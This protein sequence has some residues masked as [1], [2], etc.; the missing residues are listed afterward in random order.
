M[1]MSHFPRKFG[2]L[3]CCVALSACTNGVVAASDQAPSTL[4]SA[5]SSAT[6]TT[7]TEFVSSFTFD[8]TIA[9]LESALEKRNLKT[10]AKIDH[11][12]GAASIGEDLNP[13]TLFIFGNPRGGTPLMKLDQRLGLVLPLKAL[14]W[15]NSEGEVRLRILDLKT[16]V[17]PFGTTAND[18][19]ALAMRADRISGV[20]NGIAL[21]ATKGPK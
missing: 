18:K 16:E 10:F 5:S 14:V 4:S 1:T 11:A 12:K 6:N 2:A 3:F 9:K 20:L 17:S 7:Q 13:T 8:D 15:E 21:E 19:A